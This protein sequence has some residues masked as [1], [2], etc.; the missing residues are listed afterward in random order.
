V[1]G[2]YQFRPRFVARHFDEG[3]YIAPVFRFE[4]VRLDRTLKNFFL[5]RTRATL[6]LNIAPSSGVIF[7]LNYLFNRTA[8][9]V[10]RLTEGLEEEFGRRLL[11]FKGYGRDGFAGSVTYVF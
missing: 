4:G 11:P 1:E 10:P 7:K 8:A 2:S 5:N 6:G 3:G 9:P